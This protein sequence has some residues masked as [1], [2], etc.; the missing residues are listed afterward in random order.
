M[1]GRRLAGGRALQSQCYSWCP[2]AA[3]SV[4]IEA[5]PKGL[6]GGVTTDYTPVEPGNRAQGRVSKVIRVYYF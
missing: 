6:E 4:G 2:L 3:G 5:P 1:T